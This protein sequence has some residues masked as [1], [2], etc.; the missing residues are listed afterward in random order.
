MAGP[1]DDDQVAA[2]ELGERPTAF[3]V[4][5][6]VEVTVDHQDGYPQSATLRFEALAGWGVE[7]L[8]F[9]ARREDL[10]G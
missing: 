4:L 6:D 1:L 2:G 8:R 10:A 5:A 7:V 3:D 9:L